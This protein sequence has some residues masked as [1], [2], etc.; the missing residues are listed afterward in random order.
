MLHSIPFIGKFISKSEFTKNTLILTLGTILAQTI[1]ILFHP[2]IRRIYSPENFGAFSL[3]LNMIGFVIILATLRYEAAIVLPKNRIAAANILGLSFLINSTISSLL[4]FFLLFF[5]NLF[6]NLIGYP[7]IYSNYLYFLPFSALF[8]SFYQSINYWLIREKAF[9]SSSVNKISRRSSEGIIQ[10]GLG[11]NHY[12]F[13]LIIGDLIGNLTNFISGIIQIKKHNFKL[14]YISKKKIFYAA[15]KYKD[16]PLYNFFP[17]LLSSAASILPFFFINKFYSSENVGYIDLSRMVLSIPLV[18]ISATISQVFFQ[19]TTEKKNNE[20]S[21]KKDALNILYILL[22]IVF[23]EVLFILC[24][25]PIFFKIIFGDQYEISGQFSKILVFSFALNFISA[26]FSSIFIT[27]QKLRYNSRWQMTYFC[28]ICSLFFIHP[29][30]IYNFLKAYVFIEIVMHSINCL[31]I[32][33][34]VNKYEKGL[35]TLH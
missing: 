18:F 4:L 5:K 19:Q 21:I 1:P 29:L 25:G 24:Y 26:T 22:F 8:F 12:S 16:F 15:K 30:S 33:T 3:Y 9:K 23:F 10:L 35:K 6:C 32:Y 27:F 17:T 7:L 13:G 14:T 11:Y 34:I 2:L 28:L 31:M 20:L